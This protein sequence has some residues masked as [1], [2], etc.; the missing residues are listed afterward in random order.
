MQQLAGASV[1]EAGRRRRRDALV[2]LLAVNSG[3]TD[4][5]GFISLGGA[6]TSVMTGNMVLLGI[7]GGTGNSSLAAHSAGAIVCFVIGGALGARVAGQ[8][9]PDDPVWPEQVGTALRIEFALIGVYALGWEAFGGHPRG[10]W[11]AA[12][13]GVNAVALGLQS[14]AIHRFGVPG[15]STTY[16]TGTLTTMVIRLTHGRGLRDVAHSAQLL[17]GLVAGAGSGAFL[18]AHVARAAPIVQLV[19]L[20]TVA[21]G[22]A[23]WRPRRPR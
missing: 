13:L 23:N 18:A 17:A 7:S 2:V 9:D 10:L 8:P 16:L 11:A 22:A 21:I 14:S 6:F 5:I 4:A 20:G 3:A 1:T 19:S 12:L 15:L